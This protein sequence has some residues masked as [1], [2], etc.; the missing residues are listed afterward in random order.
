MKLK[1]DENIKTRLKAFF[2]KEG[3]A[4]F[5]RMVVVA[6]A[7]FLLISMSADVG[8]AKDK[9][10]IEITTIVLKTAGGTLVSRSPV[11][12][13]KFIGIS[14]AEG[15]IFFE[16]DAKMT[17]KHKRSFDAISLGDRVSV[18]YEEHSGITESGE[19]YVKR[20]AKSVGYAGPATTEMKDIMDRKHNLN[21]KGD[22]DTEE[23]LS[24]QDALVSLER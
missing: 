12:D 16:V 20:I 18:A 7:M 13:P 4:M 15:D 22:A 8:Y 10:A 21:R 6:V 3:V 11:K 2:R 14:S 23:D 17:T 9:K 24:V 19:P 1:I 5:T